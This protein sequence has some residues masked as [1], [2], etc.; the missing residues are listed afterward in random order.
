MYY[1]IMAEICFALLLV[2]TGFLCYGAYSVAKLVYSDI[3][4]REILD[5]KTGLLDT[6]MVLLTFSGAGFSLFM[7]A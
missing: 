5:W 3:R 1:L 2:M 7:S 6:A 4:D